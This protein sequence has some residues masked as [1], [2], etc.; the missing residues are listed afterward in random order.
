MNKDKYEKF[1]PLSIRARCLWKP[2]TAVFMLIKGVTDVLV[3]GHKVNRG[4]VCRPDPIEMMLS[5]PVGSSYNSGQVPYPAVSVSLCTIEA[6]FLSRILEDS[7]YCLPHRGMTIA[8]MCEKRKHM[9]IDDIAEVFLGEYD[10]ITSYKKDMHDFYNAVNLL[11]AD[12][13]TFT[14]LSALMDYFEMPNG[15]LGKAM[16][17]YAKHILYDGFGPGRGACVEEGI[18]KATKKYLDDLRSFAN[19]L[20]KE[21]M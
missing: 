19:A 4:A 2:S 12:T 17:L 5:R 15:K 7:T 9:T 18:T 11:V 16:V 3:K 1:G 13:T 14:N 8:E 10:R 21:G 6:L 20:C